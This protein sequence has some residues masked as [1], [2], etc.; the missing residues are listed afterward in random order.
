MHE[1]SLRLGR[2]SAS[3][4]LAAEDFTHG[5]VRDDAAFISRSYA[6]GNLSANIRPIKKRLQL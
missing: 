6:V 4:S 2:V 1:L 3:K 5:T